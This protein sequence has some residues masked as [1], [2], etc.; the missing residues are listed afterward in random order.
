MDLP[1]T[2]ARA[3]ATSLDDHPRRGEISP[4]TPRREMLVICAEDNGTV[5]ISN[6]TV[7]HSLRIWKLARSEGLEPPT[8]EP[9]R[10]RRSFSELRAHWWVRLDMNQHLPLRGALLELHTRYFIRGNSPVIGFACSRSTGPMPTAVGI[11]EPSNDG[12]MM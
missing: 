1:S 2:L 3:S 5:T 7:D 6:T 10:A 4:S 8:S 12:G 9:F 11:F